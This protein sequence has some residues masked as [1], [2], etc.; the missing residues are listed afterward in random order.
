MDR[1]VMDEGEL[2]ADVQQVAQHA[3]GINGDDENGDGGR[4]PGA[5]D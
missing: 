4:E 1:A 3:H 5:G 2:A